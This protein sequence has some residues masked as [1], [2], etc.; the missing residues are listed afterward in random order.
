MR[1][2][3]SALIKT[4][5]ALL[6]KPDD[7]DNLNLLANILLEFDDPESEAQALRYYDKA[8]ALRPELPDAY[9]GKAQYL[10]TWRK[11]PDPAEAERLARKALKLALR[12]IEDPEI[13]TLK[14]S[15]LIDILEGRRKFEQARTVLRFA[16]RKCP[17]ELMRCLAEGTL[18]RIG[19]R[20]RSAPLKG[21]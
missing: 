5:R 4:K 11:P 15:T 7:Y 16:L 13:L 21:R 3:R 9:E 14:F 8:I 12:R 20:S 1:M 6:L 17:T 18:R 10:M 19:V 2:V